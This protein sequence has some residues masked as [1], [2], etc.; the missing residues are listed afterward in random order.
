M[1]CVMF[2]WLPGLLLIKTIYTKAVYACFFNRMKFFTN[3]Y[4]F[5]C[6]AGP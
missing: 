4:W 5:V 2:H 1:L 3:S 6:N